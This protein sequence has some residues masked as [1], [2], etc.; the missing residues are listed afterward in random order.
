MEAADL[1]S[2]G[3]LYFCL[4]VMMSCGR[5]LSERGTRGSREHAGRLVGAHM[6]LWQRKEGFKDNGSREKAWT[7]TQRDENMCH[8]QG[9]SSEMVT[10]FKI[11]WFSWD[12]PHK[13]RFCP[14]S[15]QFKVTI[16]ISYYRKRLIYKVPGIILD[17]L[18][19]PIERQLLYS[20][21]I[22]TANIFATTFMLFHIYSYIFMW[23]ITTCI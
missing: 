9:F 15:K 12:R 14:S 6:G 18:S 10:Y 8:L 23:H 13:T 11:L 22:W 3:A 17:I 21:N 19:I 1:V 16:H 20:E 5:E 2:F 4:R 7:K